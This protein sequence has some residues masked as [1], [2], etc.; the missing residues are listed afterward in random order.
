MHHIV[1]YILKAVVTYSLNTYRRRFQK[2]YAVF[3]TVGI[4]NNIKK[5]KCLH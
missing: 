5:I 4:C 2:I 3:K 1:V